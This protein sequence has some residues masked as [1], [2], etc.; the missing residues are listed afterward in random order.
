MFQFKNP[1]PDA[2]KFKEIIKGEANPLRAHFLELSINDEVMMY[3]CKNILKRE[4]VGC[5]GD[6]KDD[7]KYWDNL[8]DIFYRLGYDTFDINI[9]LDFPQSIEPS[10]KQ[11]AS[12]QWVKMSAGPIQNFEDFE[13]YPWPSPESLDLRKFEYI[14]QKLPDGM[15]LLLTPTAGFFG[16][17]RNTLMGFENLSYLLFDNPEL[18]RAVFEKVAEIITASYKKIIGLPKLAG[19][20]QCDDMGF[21]SSTLISPEHLRKYSLPGHRK[22]SEL[23]HDNSLLYL[24]HSC[25]NLEE[26]MEDLI[27]DVKIDAKHSFEDKIIPV[28]EFKEKYGGR[29]GIMG[30]IDMDKL[31][32][33]EG[34]MLRNY[35]RKVLEACM[36]NGRYILGSGNSIA[37]YV[38]LKNYLI[39]MEEGWNWK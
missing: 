4:W 24:L 9:E 17:P 3:V 37:D 1:S 21:K 25:G 27:E 39:M 30:G 16:T 23:V 6:F 14:S 22:V 20:F 28:T 33:L 38:P 32:T 2:S 8:I 18:V 35:I 7:K 34:D 10:G 31:C 5:T 29:I 11:P 12:S 36:R 13:K 15:E 19:F 26:I